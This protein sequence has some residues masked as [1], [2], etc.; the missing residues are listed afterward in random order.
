MNGAE[1]DA[2]KSLEQIAHCQGTSIVS[3][4]MDI[5]K[6]TFKQ[7]IFTPFLENLYCLKRDQPQ[8]KSLHLEKINARKNHKYVALSYTWSEPMYEDLEQGGYE[9]RSRR[10]GRIYFDPS[11]VKDC[12]FDRIFGYMQKFG[13]H[14]L[15]IDQHSI[16]QKAC[17]IE[18]HHWRCNQKRK[19]LNAMDLVYRLSHHPVALLATTIENQHD[20]QLLGHILGGGLVENGE[21]ERHFKFSEGTTQEV[22]ETA[23]E[24]LKKMTGDRWWTRGWIFQESYRSGA[25][26]KLLVRH[27]SGL[28][29]LKLSIG[30]SLFGELFGEL[31]INLVDFSYQATRLCLAFKT[32]WPPQPQAQDA[33]QQILTTAGRYTLLLEEHESM[34]PTIISDI[35]RRDL[36]HQWDRLT[37]VANCCQYSTRLKIRELQQKDQSLS[38]SMLALWL[39][40]GEI[41]YNKGDTGP[42]SKM[43]VLDFLTSH[44]FKGFYAPLS[45]RSLSFNKGCRF[46]YV[47]LTRDGVSTKG[48][49]WKLGKR[50][51][52][53]EIHRQSSC[54][55]KRRQGN[56]RPEVR[57]RL[58][59][60]A[61]LLRNRGYSELEH[62]LRTFL[63]RNMRD[64]SD[65]SSARTFAGKYMQMMAEEVA[66][67]ISEG[68][69]LR[70]ACLQK[71]REFSS[72]EPNFFGIHGLLSK[73]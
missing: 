71:P 48:H 1:D 46:P 18:C 69:T 45:R 3:L 20:L 73:T 55:D 32:M 11:M 49:L 12:I 9:V 47:K 30:K 8:A 26:M 57:R 7:E 2:E 33:I 52:S 38:L 41:F 68:L 29:T 51:S 39:L 40:N 14:H 64:G 23:V 17:E 62:Q 67:A 70:L 21:R 63:K 31:C 58:T 6:S 10:K 27:A 34:S 15:W 53:S 36:E 35:G 4:L 72:G 13:L 61:D 59:Q 28:E 22:I 56:L 19:G 44:S 54:E 66:D 65:G 50:I 60:L 16:P 5:Q 43:N 37:I 25:E 24:L 42:L